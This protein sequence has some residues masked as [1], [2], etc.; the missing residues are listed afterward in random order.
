M[1][2]KRVIALM[3][4]ALFAA[5]MF[6]GCGGKEKDEG[7]TKAVYHTD[8]T[9]L[10]TLEPLA[11]PGAESEWVMFALLDDNDN[12]QVEGLSFLLTAQNETISVDEHSVVKVNYSTIAQA[13][14]QI[15]SVTAVKEDGTQAIVPVQVK[16]DG[17]VRELLAKNGSSVGDPNTFELQTAPNL[18][19]LA[20][21]ATARG[22]TPTAPPRVLPNA[23]T[24]GSIS[25]APTIATTQRRV[26]TTDEFEWARD[27]ILSSNMTSAEKQRALKMLSY[28][29]D[30]NGIFYVEKEPWQ[31]QFGFNA[32]YDM[33]APWMQLVYATVRVK[34]TYDY[35]YEIYTEGPN[36]GKVVRDDNGDP[37]YK[38]GEDGKPIPK[39]WMIQL[40]KGRYGLLMLGAEIGVYTKPHTQSAQHYNSAVEE[41]EL[42]MK[43]S[44]YQHSFIDNKTKFLFTR[45]PASEWWQTGFVPGSFENPDA[46]NSGKDEIILLFELRFPNE[47]MLGLFT[48]GMVSAGFKEGSPSSTRVET[49]AIPNST[50]FRCSWQFIDQDS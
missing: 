2:M 33:V 28:K 32:L 22:A 44:C 20:P 11:A 23:P 10:E 13:K 45:G 25:T 46:H 7:V 15:L 12:V 35:V 37:V 24:G 39:D 30:E 50:T 29:M 19:T 43:M 38:V 3:L 42:V 40:W 26:T 9:E 31:K 27:Q 34:F 47:E 21:I 48:D 41:E 6:A 16:E 1:F 17:G 5:A 4:C 36:K 8:P 14:G 18:E 49:Y